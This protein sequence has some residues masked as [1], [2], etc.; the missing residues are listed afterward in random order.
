MSSSGIDH[1][2]LVQRVKTIQKMEGGQDKWT[3]YL[4]RNVTSKR[5]PARHSPQFLEDFLSEFE[6]GSPAF[7]GGVYVNFSSGPPKGSKFAELVA[8]VKNGQRTSHT[9]KEA[10]W[11]FV[12]EHGNDVRDPAK[13]D[14]AFL[15]KFLAESP[16]TPNVGKFAAG[17]QPPAD[18]QHQELIQ[19][20]KHGQRTSPEFKEAW[21]TFVREFA[22]D[23][24]DPSRHDAAF[25][26]S[27]LATAPTVNQPAAAETSVVVED[28]E[29]RALVAQVKEQQ[30]SSPEFKEA[31]AQHVLLHGNVRDPAKHS[32]E[33]L[34]AFLTQAASEEGQGKGYGK[35]AGK[36]KGFGGKGA[37]G[38]GSAYRYSPY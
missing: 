32:S 8:Q 3:A 18:E 22:Q 35:G 25:L 20:V 28:D 24:R 26:Q 17:G 4:D 6:H 2:T 37:C 34:Q 27:F 12:Q 9:F 5:D 29:H 38:W 30:R 31:W 13:H 23:N 10:W 11:A 15:S 7:G 1:A 16:E 19:W 14:A 33:F 36:G 21:I